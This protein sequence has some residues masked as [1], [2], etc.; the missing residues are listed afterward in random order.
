V[1]ARGLV[2]GVVAGCFPQLYE[3]LSGNP[4]DQVITL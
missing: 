3:A 4:P 1:K 2:E